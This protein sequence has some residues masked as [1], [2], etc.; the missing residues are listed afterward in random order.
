VVSVFLLPD[1]MML[2]SSNRH[3]CKYV[4]DTKLSPSSLEVEIA[5]D[6]CET[7]FHWDSPNKNKIP[8]NSEMEK[9]QP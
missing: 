6:W 2:R 7:G 5:M 1:S 4:I 3:F 8:G 9:V